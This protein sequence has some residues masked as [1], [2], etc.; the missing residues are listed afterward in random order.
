[1]VIVG[2]GPRQ[3]RF[4]CH[5]NML[6]L[7]KNRIS[8]SGQYWPNKRRFFVGERAPF[9]NFY[10]VCPHFLFTHRPIGAGIIFTERAFYI[11]RIFLVQAA[12]PI[13][14]RWLGAP[15]QKR[16]TWV[17]ALPTV[18][19][20]LNFCLFCAETEICACFQQ[21]RHVQKKNIIDRNGPRTQN[22]IYHFAEPPSFSLCTSFYICTFLQT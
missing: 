5:L 2:L 22:N 19:N 11:S 12:S 21:K 13:Q 8:V 3:S 4:T 18:N 10:L 14:A 17:Y 20:R 16:Y 15:L 1:M 9:L 6:I 7:C